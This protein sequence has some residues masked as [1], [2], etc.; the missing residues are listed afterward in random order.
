MSHPY[1][2]A[3]VDYDSSKAARQSLRR[4]R[5]FFSLISLVSLISLM[6]L[7]S[8]LSLAGLIKLIK[9]INSLNLLNSL[10]LSLNKKFDEFE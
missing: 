1:L 9:P 2:N 10:T 4:G 8:L 6:G 3:I 5:L 7:M